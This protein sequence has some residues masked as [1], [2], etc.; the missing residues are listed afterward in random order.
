MGE[1]IGKVVMN[2]LNPLMIGSM[3][4]YRAIEGKTVAQA[5]LNIANKEPKQVVFNS[6]EVEEWGNR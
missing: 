3:K 2:I 4:K 5:M 1:N 6:D